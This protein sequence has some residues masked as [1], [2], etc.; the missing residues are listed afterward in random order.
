[1]AMVDFMPEQ[2]EKKYG[3]SKDKTNQMVGIFCP[4]GMVQSVGSGHD[5]SLPL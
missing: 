1:M 4:P 2:M 5:E 3:N